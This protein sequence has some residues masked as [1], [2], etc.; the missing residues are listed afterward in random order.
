MDVLEP[1]LRKYEEL[2]NP[3]LG[4]HV[5]HRRG[6]CSG[7]IFER[8]WHDHLQFILF[9]K[10]ES[11]LHGHQGAVLLKA[12]ELAVIN[13]GEMHSMDEVFYR[14]HAPLPLDFVI[15]KISPRFLLG[16]FLEP[17]LDLHHVFV[18]K[19]AADPFPARCIYQILDEFNRKET[20][21]ELSVRSC[22]LALMAHLMRHHVDQVL[23]DEASGKQQMRWR[24]MGSVLEYV[25]EHFAEELPLSRL[26]EIACLSPAHFCR[27]FKKLTGFTTRDY[28]MNLRVRKAKEQLRETDRPVAEIGGSVG[29]PDSNYFSR[30]FRKSVGCSPKEFRNLANRTTAKG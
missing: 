13:S 14:N 3:E 27:N 29:F 20:G 18:N 1:A 15:L 6:I 19:V 17:M 23:S 9:E 28:L 22:V 25:E 11:I 8:H 5:A 12:G 4:I 26:A 24:C 10:G 16:P 2:P 30:V 7:P 21:W